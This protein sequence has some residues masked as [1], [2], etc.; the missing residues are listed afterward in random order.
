[1]RRVTVD[2][3]QR[4][5]YQRHRFREERWIFVEGNGLVILEGKRMPVERG[6]YVS[7]PKGALH[8]VE[9]TGKSPLVFI[10]VQIGERLDEEDIERIEDDYGRT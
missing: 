8:R 4:L 10:E 5:S 9:N 3:G 2:P 1:M 6:D 7:I